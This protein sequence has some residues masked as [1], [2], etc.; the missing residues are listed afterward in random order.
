MFCDFHNYTYLRLLLLL[1]TGAIKD[2]C[3]ILKHLQE[4]LAAIKFTV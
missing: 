2:S 1:C 3:S 4:K